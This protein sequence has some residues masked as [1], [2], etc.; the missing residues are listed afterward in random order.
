MS[1][2]CVYTMTG[3]FRLEGSCGRSPVQT[4]AQ[5]NHSQSWGQIRLPWALSR[6]V[7]KNLHN[8]SGQFFCSAVWHSYL[9]IFHFMS[10][11]N[12]LCFSLL[13]SSHLSAIHCCEELGSTFLM[14]VGSGKLLLLDVL[15]A[16][17]FL[18]WASTSPSTSPNRASAPVSDQPPLNP[19][20]LCWCLHWFGM[21]VLYY[22][23]QN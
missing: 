12:F 2:L 1:K 14:P 15:E 8:F 19:R 3:T 22:R 6:Q 9:K 18:D 13:F 23:A 5:T 10:R 21:S 17:T 11:I 16:S 20:D 7:L 4:P